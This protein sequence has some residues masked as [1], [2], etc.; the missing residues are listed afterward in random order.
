MYIA[1]SNLAKINIVDADNETYSGGSQ[2]WFTERWRK[3]SG[4]GAVAASNLIWYMIDTR[5]DKEHYLKIMNEM[6]AF[7]TPGIF[8]VNNSAIFINGAKRYGTRHEIS[9]TA[10]KLEIPL[11]KHKRPSMDAVNDFIA[12]A[13]QSDAPVA[14]LNLS[15]GNTNNLGSWH[16]V[17]IIAF[18]TD[19]LRAKI[20]DYGK[21]IEI[22]T[23][24]WLK[25]S[26]LGG[27]FVYFNT[28]GAVSGSSI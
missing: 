22:D 2:E 3:Q 20:S 5:G 24:L 18:D 12:S 8:G 25:S 1:L 27:V 6:F 19:T 7:V 28:S 16:W 10:H 4:C 15:N 13:L 26:L 21:T 9:I 14:F 17:T 23:S 11:W